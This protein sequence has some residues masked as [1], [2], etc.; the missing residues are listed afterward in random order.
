MPQEP[1]VYSSIAF[2]YCF[3]LKNLLPRALQ[4]SASTGGSCCVLESDFCRDG[5]ADESPS[6]SPL[7]PLVPLMPLMPLVVGVV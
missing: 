7:T 6:S 4:A 2:S 1:F 3:V 5:L